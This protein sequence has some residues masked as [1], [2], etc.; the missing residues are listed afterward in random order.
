MQLG[1]VAVCIRD[2]GVREGRELQGIDQRDAKCGT[3]AWRIFQELPIKKLVGKGR[4]CCNAW[5]TCEILSR[6]SN[7]GLREQEGLARFYELAVDMGLEPQGG[8][9]GF[10]TCTTAR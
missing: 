1:G 2:V 9:F 3:G 4:R 6:T 8:E 5:R 7:P 10:E